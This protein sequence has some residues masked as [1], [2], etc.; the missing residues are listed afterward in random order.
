MDR[1]NGHIRA[2]RGE[3]VES[4]HRVHAVVADERGDLLVWGVSGYPTTLR[5]AAKLFQALPLVEDGVADALP[6]S[7]AELALCCASHNSESRHV[8]GARAILARAGLD[9]T[10]LACGPHRPL[11]EESARAMDAEGTAPTPIHNNCSGKHAGMLA[12]AVHHGWSPAGY[13]LPDHPVQLR[14]LEEVARWSGVPSAEIPRGVDGCGIPCYALALGVMARAF[15][16]FGT[17]A[18]P[19][20]TRLLD[21]IG[22]APGMIAGERRLCSTLA[23]AT[24][25]R[26]VAKVGAEGV[27]GAIVRDRGL[28]IAIKVEDGARRA[29]EPALLA[30]LHAIEALTPEESDRLGAFV[31]PVIRNTRDEV[32]GA[33]EFVPGAAAGTIERPGAGRVA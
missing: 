11:D 16:R 6:L 3:I 17:T 22:A 13:H 20:P 31:A 7:P 5:S 18:E 29:V 23:E 8:E 4:E 33:L 12:L 19:G 1:M 25:G 28:G 14:M 21:A 2:V 32:V 10:A 9:E 27:Y 30:V 24:E 15:R 26:I